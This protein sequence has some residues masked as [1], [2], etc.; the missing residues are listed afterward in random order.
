MYGFK[1]ISVLK[2]SGLDLQEK[3][4]LFWTFSG[5]PDS[6][7]KTHLQS[8]FCSGCLAA[9]WLLKLTGDLSSYTAKDM[10]PSYSCFFQYI[11]AL[12]LSVALCL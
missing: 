3:S 5:K 4:R 11:I 9:D 8:A 7:P 10:I 1:K 2:L 6:A 12:L